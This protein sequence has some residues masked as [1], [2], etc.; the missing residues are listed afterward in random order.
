MSKSTR[1]RP[2]TPT[3]PAAWR[4]RLTRLEAVD[5]IRETEASDDPAPLGY[6]RCDRCPVV[7]VDGF[8][9]EEAAETASARQAI[10]LHILFCPGRAA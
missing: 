10:R 3:R 7:I 2:G 1:R 5:R 9:P 8:D 4:R 6:T